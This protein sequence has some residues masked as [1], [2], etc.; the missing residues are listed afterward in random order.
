MQDTTDA[1]LKTQRGYRTQRMQD[2]PGC[3]QEQRMQDTTDAGLNGSRTQRMQ[4]T[5]DAGHKGYRTQRMQ[6]TKD[7]GHRGFRI[8]Y[9]TQEARHNRCRT[10]R[11]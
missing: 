3:M 5:K 7:S 10:Q 6:N 8:Q 1:G 4:G 9:E 11:M 2:T